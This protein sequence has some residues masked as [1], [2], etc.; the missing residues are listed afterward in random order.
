[1]SMTFVELAEKLAEQHDV[2]AL[3]EL[4]KITPQEL[5][6]AFADKIEANFS[7]LV[8]EVE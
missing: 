7:E 6:E 2:E 4:L 3:C 1:M 8:D 5:V